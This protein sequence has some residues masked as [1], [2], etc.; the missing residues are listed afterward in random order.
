VGLAAFK[1]LLQAVYKGVLYPV[2]PKANSIQGVKAYPNLLDIPDEVDMALVIVAGEKVLSVIEQAAQKQV[3][4]CIVISA[5]FKEVG[6]HGAELE[7]ELKSLVK[8]HGIRLVGPNCLRI[9]NTD[10]RLSMNATFARTMPK[11]GN[12]AFISQSGAL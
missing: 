5:G 2:H 10:T 1:N 4:G 12:I 7:Q 3:K 11:S 6:G 9:I 8:D